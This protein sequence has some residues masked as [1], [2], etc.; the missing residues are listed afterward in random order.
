LGENFFNPKDQR[1]TVTVQGVELKAGDRVRIRPKR[2]ADAFD[3][4]L[5]G[6][7]AVIEA[8]EEDVQNEIHLALVVEDEPGR[9]LGMSRQ[10]GHRFFYGADEVELL[11]EGE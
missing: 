3:M 9:E 4:M 2:R 10:P 5:N 6:R 11:A 8:V 7:I 1:K